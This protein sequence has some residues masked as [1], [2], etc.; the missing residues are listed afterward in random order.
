VLWRELLDE[1]VDQPA[2]KILTTQVGITS[3]GL[4]LEDT[5]FD[6]PERDLKN[7]TAEVK[8]ENVMLT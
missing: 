7:T 4:D 3:D 1:G 5:F 6:G 2:V 8:N